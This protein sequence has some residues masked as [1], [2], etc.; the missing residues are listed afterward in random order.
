[1]GPLTVSGA[2]LVTITRNYHTD[3]AMAC[4]CIITTMYM[5]VPILAMCTMYASVYAA[6][7]D[8]VIDV[9]VYALLPMHICLVCK[10]CVNYLFSSYFEVTI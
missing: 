10:Y 1:M 2:I 9:L 8:H 4:R 5:P 7:Y 3:D 6:E